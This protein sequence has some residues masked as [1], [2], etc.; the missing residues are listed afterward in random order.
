MG[1]ADRFKSTLDT[2][3]IFIS[4]NKNIQG[5]KKTISEPLPVK[6]IPTLNEDKTEETSK[7]PELVECTLKKI[8]NTPYW[9]DYSEK[10]QEKMVS[11][12]FN[13]KIQG[14]QYSGIKIS[15]K[16]KLLFIQDV[17]GAINKI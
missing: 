5:L 16:D 17:L 12:Y 13:K 3:D 10:E 14:E 8:E 4:P 15:L 1:L 7:F 6:V 2:A 11:K 9:N